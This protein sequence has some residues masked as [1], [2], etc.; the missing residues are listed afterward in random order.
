MAESKGFFR[1]TPV[2]LRVASLLDHVGKN[3]PPDCFLPQTAS[4]PSL[5]ESL[6]LL[7]C[8]SKK[9]ALRPAFHFGGELGIFSVHSRAPS[10]RFAPWPH[11]QKQSTGL[12]SSAD[13]VCSLLVRTLFLFCQS[14][15]QALRPAFHFGGELGIR[16]LGTL[17]TQH[18]ECCTFD[19]SDN[20][21]CFS[22]LRHARLHI[23]TCIIPNISILVNKNKHQII[24]FLY[25]LK[26]Y[27]PIKKRSN[28]K[29]WYNVIHH[30]NIT[31]KE[32]LLIN[33]I[34]QEAGEK[35]AI[36]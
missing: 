21:P 26:W 15:K 5:F 17:R 2:H 4:A 30:K 23:A 7:F 18:F 12:F 35:Q 6:F 11:R 10:R 33:V 32:A 22:L 19:H 20:S 25:V 14:K 1:R 24:N 36:F 29:K 13:F 34:T 8:Q 16:T 9:Q 3:S 27:D 28:L 31:K